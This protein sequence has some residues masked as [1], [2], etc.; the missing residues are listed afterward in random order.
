VK[1]ARL[2]WT[3]HMQRRD[4]GYIRKRMV[5]MKLPDLRKR[6]RPK[7]RFIDVVREDMQVGIA[8]EDAEDRKTWK[9]MIHCGDP[10]WEQPIEVFFP[11]CC[12]THV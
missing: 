5:K 2:R 10:S 8:E 11:T 9:Q 4:A 12:W 6:G 7:R 3:E 1:E